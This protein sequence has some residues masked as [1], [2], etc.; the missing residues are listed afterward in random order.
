MTVDQE[1]GSGHE[2]RIHSRGIVGIGP[3]HHEAMPVGAV[4]LDFG[5]YALKE[6]L[7]KLQNLFHPHAENEGLAGGRG[8]FGEYDILRVIAAGRKYGGTLIDLGGIEK[9]EDRK[10]LDLEDFVHAFETESALV[11]EGVGDMSLFKSRLMSKSESGQF[12]CFDAV[13]E[14]FTEV[15]L[16][17]FELHRRSIAPG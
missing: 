17:D 3:D 1:R 13:P 11:V 8:G 2:A 15:F 16:Q 7:F 4:A 14:D 5:P 12:T 10:M 6:R 9:V